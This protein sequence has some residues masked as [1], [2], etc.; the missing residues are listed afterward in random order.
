MKIFTLWPLTFIYE[1]RQINMT[2]FREIVD[3]LD[4]F[5]ESADGLGLTCIKGYP[6]FRQLNLQPPVTALFYAGSQSQVEG[7]RKRVGASMTA[8]VVT[9]GI[10]AAN[11]AQLFEL[12][13]RLQTIRERRPK[14]TAGSTKVQIYVGDDERTPPDEDAPKEER[15][16]ITCPVVLAYE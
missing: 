9:L 16:F 8:V 13:F 6:D 5:V 14:L 7:V 11:E 10:Y 1:G 2:T 15:H 12:A 3:A 4:A